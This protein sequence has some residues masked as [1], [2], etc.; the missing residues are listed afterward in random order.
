M[1]PPPLSCHGLTVASRG[2]QSGSWWPLDCPV[3]LGNDRGEEASAVTKARPAHRPPY[4]TQ[5]RKPVR[6]T[7]TTRPNI[8]SPMAAA[9]KTAANRRS[10]W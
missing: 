3:K 8:S 5:R 6:S 7:S 10:A 9:T 1:P 2:G 4:R